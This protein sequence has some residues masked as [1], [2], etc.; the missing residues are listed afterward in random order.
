MIVVMY[1][2]RTVV[3]T[4]DI[5]ST[6][7]KYSMENLLKQVVC[8]HKAVTIDLIKGQWYYSNTDI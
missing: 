4:V 6:T 2:S 3:Y 7:N 8:F 5:K 1:Y